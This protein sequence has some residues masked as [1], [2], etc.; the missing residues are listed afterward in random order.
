MLSESKKA[1]EIDGNRVFTSDFRAARHNYKNVKF[2]RYKD[3]DSARKLPAFICVSRRV[4]DGS[5]SAENQAEKPCRY[6]PLA[7]YNYAG[8]FRLL[9][10]F[11]ACGRRSKACSLL[12]A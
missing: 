10:A 4:V 9:S 12:R 5:Q 3:T 7:A 8:I 1:T 2:A 11:R 6:T